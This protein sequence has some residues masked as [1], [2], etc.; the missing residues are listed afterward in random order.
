MVAGL[1]AISGGTCKIGD[2]VLN[3]LQPK[4]RDIAMVFQN[5]ALYPHMTVGENMGFSLR[6]RGAPKE[7]KAREV[8]RAAKILGMDHLL[9]RYPGQLSGGQR[10]RVAMG[11]AIVRDPAL[12]LFDEPL[13]NL[14]AQLR[15]LMRSE[16]KQLHEDLKTTM[17]YVTHDQVE[18]MTMAD[19]IVVMRGGEIEQAGAPLELYDRPK[20]IFVAQFL[21]SP[22]M[23]FFDGVVEADG[24]R[25][26]SVTLPRPSGVA[27]R[28]GQPVK[29]GIRP[30]AIRIGGEGSQAEIT[31][32]EP[33]GSETLVH[34]RLDGEPLKILVRERFN[35]RIHDKVALSFDLTE[36]RLFDSETEQAIA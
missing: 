34:A 3:R 5:Y 18:A 9:D 8:E 20:N 6:L 2:R 13:S 30:E 32:I 36:L 28:P 26:N 14:D 11:R 23:N 4:E 35:G 33:T 10:Q 19:R 12:F 25:L 24:I 27:L 21:G 29:L 16:I 1:E 7:E 22:P 17:I 31:L 15:V